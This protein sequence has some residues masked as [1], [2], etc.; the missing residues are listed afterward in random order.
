MASR[1]F[2]FA[3]NEAGLANDALGQDRVL[4]SL[5]HYYIQQRLANHV[6][7]Y[8]LANNVGTSVE[9]IE[10]FYGKFP[11]HSLDQAASINKGMQKGK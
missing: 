4:Y 3:V 8:E 6:P 2:K 10:R 9:M 5:R 1:Q 7:V 11:A